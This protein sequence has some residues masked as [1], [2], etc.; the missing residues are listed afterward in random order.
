MKKAGI[1]GE[2]LPWRDV[3]HEGPVPTGLVLEELSRVR[4]EYIAEQGWGEAETVR[5]LFRQRDTVLK[6]CGRFEQVILWFE[7]DLY[8]QLQLIQL[9]DWFEHHRPSQTRVSLVCVEAYLGELSGDEMAA[10]HQQQ[11]PVTH[12]QLQLARTTW[13]AFRQK[14]PDAFAA[15]LDVDTSVLPFLH[16]AIC[17][18]LEEYPACA[19]GLSRTASQLL[20]V[21]AKGQ[22]AFPELFGRCQQLE[23]R[24]FLGDWS[25][26]NILGELSSSDPP[27]LQ[28]AE[29]KRESHSTEAERTVTITPFGRSVLAGEMNWM[30]HQKV[31]RWLGGVHLTLENLWCWNGDGGTIQKYR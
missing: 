22:R 4:A 31:D 11:Q 27:L 21:L 7:H 9:L 16:G 8:D 28:P 25:F 18:M 5:E 17:R 2:F 13:S 26:R 3:L 6:Q 1:P 19:S 24:R 14:T 30:D 29:K 10:L 15:L 20:S 23:E 12:E